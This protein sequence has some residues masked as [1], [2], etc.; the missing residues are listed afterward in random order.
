MPRHIGKENDCNSMAPWPALLNPSQSL[1]TCWISFLRVPHIG[2]WQ[3]ATC[4]PSDPTLITHALISSTGILVSDSSYKQYVSR[5]LGTASWIFEC[6]LTK[7]TC[8]G[9]CQTSGLEHD[10]NAYRLELQGIHAG[11]I[12][13]LAF[14]TFHNISGGSFQISC[15]NEVRVNQSSKWHLKTRGSHLG[16]SN[17]YLTT[18]ETVNL[19]HPLSHGQTPG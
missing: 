3:T 5:K 7:V 12:G 16:Y 18:Q 8:G 11:L 17:Y 4:F 9:V 19:D 15:D 2:P 13:M 1:K 14:C 10:I 6:G